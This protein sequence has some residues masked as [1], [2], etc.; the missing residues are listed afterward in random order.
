MGARA[1]TNSVSI[2]PSR[3]RPYTPMAMA[4]LILVLILHFLYIRTARTAECGPNN[5]KPVVLPIKDVL[6]D[7]SI[8]ESLMR[9]IPARIGSPP[10][11]IVLL[12]WAELNNTWIYDGQHGCSAELALSDTTCR[13]RRGSYFRSTDSQSFRKSADIVAAGGSAIEITTLGTELDVGSLVS[14]SLGGTDVFSV[15]NGD[16]ALVSSMPIGVPRLNWDHGYTTLHTLGF[17]SDSVYLRTL[18]KAGKIPSHVWSFF[19]GRT[20]SPNQIDGSV[21]L[22]GYDREKVTGQNYTQRLD[23]SEATGCWTGMKVSISGIEA[24]FWNGTNRNIIDKDQPVSVCIVPQRQHLLEAPVSV[25]TSFM[26]VT[27]MKS[28]KSSGGLQWADL[29]IDDGTTV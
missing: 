24:N 22:G 11:P 28:S 19:W 26:A 7:P 15:G 29:V 20:A 14:T 8:T 2:L 16:E 4:P 1:V 9:G 21:V 12:P 6:V 10:Q 18:V 27:S 5:A 3:C 23:Y 17:G 13:V 25:L